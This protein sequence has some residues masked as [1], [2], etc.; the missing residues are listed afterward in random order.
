MEGRII[1]TRF[2]CG[3]DL[4]KKHSRF[5]PFY[6]CEDKEGCGAITNIAKDGTP[7]EKKPREYGP[8]A[9]PLCKEKMVKRNSKMGVFFG[10]S[11]YPTCRGM[12]QEDGLPIE[13]KAKT[14][15]KFPWKGKG[16]WKGKKKSE[17]NSDE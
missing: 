9:C 15:G 4:L 2:P 11:K 17:D 6:A 3:K 1:N 8:D 12:R 16:K 10:C 7:L 13:V 5:G 14:P